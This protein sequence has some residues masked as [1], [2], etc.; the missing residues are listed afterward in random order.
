M[1]Q[2]AFNT[3][4]DP[5]TQGGYGHSDWR[6]T[7][8]TWDYQHVS[9]RGNAEKAPQGWADTTAKQTGGPNGPHL[10]GMPSALAGPWGPS[11]AATSA[12]FQGTPL[13]PGNFALRQIGS[14]VLPPTELTSFV[15]DSGMSDAIYGDEGT[16]D[17]PPYDGFDE[18]HRIE[19]GMFGNG[20]TTGHRAD[21]PSAW[22]Y[23]Q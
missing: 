17:I 9:S 19:A 12:P 14:V 16:N 4:A 22:G 2:D 13:A 21:V 6:F 23:P 15:R 10:R 8:T 18:S 1:A 5:G 20:L 11:G 3:T 7:E